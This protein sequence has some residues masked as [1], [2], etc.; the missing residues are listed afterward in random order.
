L[1]A[2]VP[3]REPI[4]AYGPFVM[5]TKEQIEKAFADYHS[6]KFGKAIDGSQERFDKTSKAI[7]SQQKSGKYPRDQEGS[8]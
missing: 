7:N 6:G 1:I 3:L 2:G 4:V 5:N 8:V